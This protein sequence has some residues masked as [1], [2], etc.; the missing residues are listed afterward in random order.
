MARGNPPPI[1][2]ERQILPQHTIFR[3]KGDLTASMVPFKYWEN[4]LFMSNFREMTPQWLQY[5]CLKKIQTF[6]IWTKICIALKHVIWRF[7]ICNYFHEIF[8]FCDFMNTLRNFAKSFFARIF[9]KFKW[10]SKAIYTICSYFKSLNFFRTAI[11]KP[12]RSHF[13]KI[14]HKIAKSK[15]FPNI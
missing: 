11:L 15:Y 4:I 1:I 7:R 5:S 13:A 12:L 14:A 2:F 3:W 8:K 10:C 6:K 9:A